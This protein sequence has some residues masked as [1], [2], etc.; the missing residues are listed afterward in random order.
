[1]TDMLAQVIA[2]SCYGHDPVAFADIF[3]AVV[4]SFHA[5]DGAPVPMLSQA[6]IERVP[7]ANMVVV[8]SDSLF[9]TY[10][11]QLSNQ[12]RPHTFVWKGILAQGSYNDVY[13]AIIKVRCDKRTCTLDH[14]QKAVI[15]ITSQAP[16][17]LRV[18]LMENVIHAIL[19][20][21]PDAAPFV[22]HMFCPFKL[23]QNTHPPFKLGCVLE[24]PGHGDMAAFICERSTD[25]TMFS[26]VVQMALMLMRMQGA[27]RFQ[28]RDF[29]A[30]NLVIVDNTGDR[31]QTISL[32]SHGIWFEYLTE[33]IG[34]KMIDFG[35]TRLELNNEYIGCDIYHQSTAFN[36]SQDIQ[37][38]VATTLEDFA[39]ALQ[40]RCSEFYRWLKAYGA[41]ITE[42]VDAR[43]KTKRARN[44]EEKN[45]YTGETTE[46]ES[47][48]MYTPEGLLQAVEPE[49]HRIMGVSVAPVAS[50]ASVASVAP[51]APVT[52][53]KAN[54]LKKEHSCNRKKVE[55]V[56]KYD[57]K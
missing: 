48:A 17:D 45:Y 12:T 41:M 9:D 30:D 21:L 51:V 24:D 33:G 39:E 37:F 5:T 31:Q 56:E 55:K 10:R 36:P 25:A 11:V 53:S 22:V 32:P 2:A 3:R 14:D 50:V 52:R 57:G 27:L 15:K 8:G 16:K 6:L 1:M 47:M 26:L 38:W 18:H 13:K 49:W 29:K 7:T 40:A 42:A 23:H 20:Q 19:N 54:R 44:S 28:H 43:C 46:R 4:R 34:C 35:M